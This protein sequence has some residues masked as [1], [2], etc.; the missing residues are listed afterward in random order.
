MELYFM[1]HGETAWSR[2]GQFTGNT[3]LP[4]TAHGE[5]EAR[6]LAPLL[7][8]VKFDHVFTSPRQRARRTAELAGYP[9]AVPDAEFAEWDY[10]DCDG[11]LLAEIQATRPGWNIYT[12]GCP[13]GESPEQIVARADRAIARLT[14]LTGRVAVFSHGHFGRVLAVRWIG[15][16]LVMAKHFAISTASCSI[17]HVAGRDQ[18]PQIVKWNLTGTLQAEIPEIR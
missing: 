12:D 13:G 14:K 9:H 11:K 6:T 15:L 5:A 7:H 17:L 18:R 16:P 8:G 1:R 4:L 2:T 3:D 10:G